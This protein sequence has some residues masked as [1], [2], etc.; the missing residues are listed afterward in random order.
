MTTYS[1]GDIIDSIENTL[2]AAASLN[3]SQSYDELTEAIMD[4]PT[5]QVYP[6]EGG[7]SEYSETDRI[8][9][10]RKSDGKKHSVK[11]YIVN[12]DLLA[13]QRANIGEDMKI[14]VDCIDEIEDIL[15]TQECP[16]FDNDNIMSFQWDPWRR[17][18]FAYSNVDYV[19]ARFTLT[20]RCG[21]VA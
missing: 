1:L 10:G 13:K 3:A 18:V 19:G 16:W 20:I 5:L 9:L 14:L 2:G 6:E 4:P 15:D 12:V 8:T 11:T 17:V 21:R 7:A